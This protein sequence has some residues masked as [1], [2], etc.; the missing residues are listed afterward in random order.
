MVSH[1][2][3]AWWAAALS[4]TVSLLISGCSSTPIASSEG[5]TAQ[6]S[7][8]AELVDTTV[9]KF[10]VI[11]RLEPLT[12]AVVTYT[13]TDYLQMES[14]PASPVVLEQIEAN[15]EEVQRQ[16][17]LWREFT[18]GIDYSATSIRG[19]ES[20][21]NAFNDGLDIWQSNQERG[22]AN[23]RKC[24][25]TGGDSVQLSLCLLS[26]YSVDDEQQALAAY[27]TPLKS[28]FDTLGVEF[29]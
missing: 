12:K 15:Y 4:I 2:S 18:S 16:E 25:T 22:L 6:G 5:P 29:Q 28:L 24:L 21:V 3:P 19:L 27:T 11:T 17:N 1:H 14:D 10:D 7:S 23:Y 26:G 8:A 9:T 20:A 13:D